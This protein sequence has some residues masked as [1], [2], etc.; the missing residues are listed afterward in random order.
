MKRN[1]KPRLELQLVSKAKPNSKSV[2]S[3]NI[4]TRS[5]LIA[6]LVAVHSFQLV[7]KILQTMRQTTLINL[8]TIKKVLTKH[9]LLTMPASLQ[10]VTNTTL[11]FVSRQFQPKNT[12]RQVTP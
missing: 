4:S 8:L 5:Q 7:V 1:I 3:A 2:C 6:I 11:V 9:T 12:V 10:V